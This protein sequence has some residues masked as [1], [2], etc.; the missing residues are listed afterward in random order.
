MLYLPIKISIWA[1]VIE[2]C[3]FRTRMTMQLTYY[4]QLDHNNVELELW[5]P[6]HELCTVFMVHFWEGTNAIDQRMEIRNNFSLLYST[7]AGDGG[8]PY[9]EYLD[10]SG[11]MQI[12]AVGLSDLIRSCPQLDHAQLFYCDNMVDDPFVTTASGCQNLEVPTR[13]CC[14]T[15]F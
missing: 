15:G 12:T 4:T 7:L 8:L 14:R 13:K 9:L 3:V 11:C 10:L 2:W 1:L 5:H 6:K